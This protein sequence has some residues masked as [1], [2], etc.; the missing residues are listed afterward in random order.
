MDN[1]P[2]T[3]K[4]QKKYF[5]HNRCLTDIL[6]C[7]IPHT[8][9]SCHCQKKPRTKLMSELLKKLSEKA[10]SESPLWWVRLLSESPYSES[11]LS[12][13]CQNHLTVSNLSES[14]SMLAK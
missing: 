10:W 4:P 7:L 12:D 9:H 2:V 3:V 11:D 13:F 8:L 14:P 1:A 5:R 6:V